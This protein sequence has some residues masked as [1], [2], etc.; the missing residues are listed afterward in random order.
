[1]ASEVGSSTNIL[2]DEVS[3]QDLSSLSILSPRVEGN[4][5]HVPP[6]CYHKHNIIWLLSAFDSNNISDSA[7]L[8]FIRLNL[9]VTENKQGIVPTRGVHCDNIR[10]Q[11]AGKYR[12]IYIHKRKNLEFS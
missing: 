4:N 1:V 8:K 3:V 12:V 10:N 2:A 5:L 9:S 6:K 11:R 7:S